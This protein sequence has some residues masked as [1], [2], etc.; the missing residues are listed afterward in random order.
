MPAFGP[1][2]LSVFDVWDDSRDFLAS[3][4]ESGAA[5]RGETRRLLGLSLLGGAEQW[6]ALDVLA[7]AWAILNGDDDGDDGRC[8]GSARALRPWEETDRLIRLARELERDGEFVEIRPPAAAHDEGGG[9]RRRGSADAA[10]KP[11]SRKKRRRLSSRSTSRYWPDEGRGGDEEKETEEED[12]PKRILGA[13][14]AAGQRL[15]LYARPRSLDLR[16]GGD[17]VSLPVGISV[18]LEDASAPP[19]C[20]RPA[21][22]HQFEG[23]PEPPPRKKWSTESPYFLKAPT[24]EEHASRDVPAR[25]PRRR[26]PAGTVSC[27]PFPP[28]DAPSF[29]LVQERVAREP[30]WLL[31][32][33]TFLIKTSGRLAIPAFWR[34]KERFPGPAEL[35][36]AEDQA[37]LL[38]MIQHL[39]LPQVRLGYIRRYARAFLEA[40]PARGVRHRVRN[41]DRRDGSPGEAVDDVG[42]AQDLEGWEIGHMTQ[43]KYALDSWRI[44]CRD[45]LLG[46]AG[47][48]TGAGRGGEFQPEWMRTR[49]DDKELRAYL[50]WMWMREGWEWDPATGERQVL[51][52]EMRR[53]VNEGRVEYDETGGLRMLESRLSED[54]PEPVPGIAA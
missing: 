33:I 3:L 8:D 22:L 24:P 48:W 43:G 16:P 11:R 36:R 39:G 52:E 34:V 29:G 18:S 20:V 27:V 21:L 9:P 2:L 32:A 53:A 15:V 6:H 28:L 35:L 44:F 1:D 50:R 37:E 45:E 31:V 51:R 54:D 12:I 25:P 10:C 49:P 19:G 7:F 47:D 23:A 5:P 26:A 40:P 4:I 38:G 13:A 41:Y 17:V 14:P 30:F 42:T 46:R